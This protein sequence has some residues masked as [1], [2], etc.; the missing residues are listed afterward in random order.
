VFACD[1]TV[2]LTPFHSHAYTHLPLLPLESYLESFPDQVNV[3][4][5]DLMP[6]RIEHEKLQRE[7]ME[8]ER[9]ELLKMKESLI[10]VNMKKREELKRMDEQIEKMIDGLKPVSEALAKDI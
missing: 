8:H 5:Q 6:L 4:E 9:Q 2:A 1:S 3:A 10:K 7:K